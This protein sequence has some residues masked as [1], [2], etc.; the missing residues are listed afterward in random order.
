MCIRDRY[1]CG[2][3][4]DRRMVQWKQNADTNEVANYQ[5]QLV[6][7]NNVKSTRYSHTII[8]VKFAHTQ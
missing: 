1:S 3:L 5:L 4:T 8:K 2:G 6:T 7:N